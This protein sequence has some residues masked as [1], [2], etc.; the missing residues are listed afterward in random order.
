MRIFIA[1]PIT[2]THVQEVDQFRI[3]N[4]R[5]LKDEVNI[6]GLR[7]MKDDTLHLTSLFVGEIDPKQLTPIQQQVK[8]I[9]QSI[10]PFNL[11][12]EK[13]CFA[14]SDKKATMIWARYAEH[15]KFTNLQKQLAAK[16]GE[17][18]MLTGLHEK[19]IPHINIARF[20]PAFT[21]N[22]KFRDSAKMSTLQVDCL[23]I[24][25]SHLDS[26]AAH[27]DSIAH[28]KMAG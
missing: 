17:I 21:A 6:H 10:S 2:Q 14:P 15:A 8:L 20:K 7:W 23:E 5:W 4:D 13:F 24:W 28:F 9:A 26:S 1:V 16:I 22:H 19:A 11:D 25:Q 27:Y 3:A 18:V 12:F